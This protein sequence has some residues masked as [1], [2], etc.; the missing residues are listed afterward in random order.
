MSADGVAER[1]GTDARVRASSYMTLLVVL[2]FVN[3]EIG[4]GCESIWIL[5][6]EPYR[7]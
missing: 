4:V 1:G 7:E 5:S 6:G 2:V 3:M